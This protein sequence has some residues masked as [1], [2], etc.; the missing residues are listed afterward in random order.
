M[1]NLE[2]AELLNSMLPDKHI[3][4]IMFVGVG[5]LEEFYEK[6]G[7][8][9]LKELIKNGNISTGYEGMKYLESILAL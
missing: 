5:Y 8:D 7:I 2:A 3:E 6:Y 4:I 1:T 9:L